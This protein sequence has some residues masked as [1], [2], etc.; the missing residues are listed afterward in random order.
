MNF[1]RKLTGMLL[2]FVWAVQTIS[3]QNLTQTI[4]GSVVDKVSLA[5]LPGAIIILVNSDPRKGA[6]TEDAADKSSK[7]EKN[8]FLKFIVI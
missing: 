3:A 5:P 2:P 6:T 4:R 8:K 1:L 7:R